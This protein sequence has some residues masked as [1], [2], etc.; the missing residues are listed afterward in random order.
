MKTRLLKYLF[1]VFFCCMA[2]SFKAFSQTISFTAL[3]GTASTY[4]SAGGNLY[5]VFGFEMKTTGFVSGSNCYIQMGTITIN[6]TQ[7]NINTYFSNAMLVQTTNPSGITSTSPSIGTVNV[8]SSNVTI[9]LNTTFSSN[10]DNTYYLVYKTANFTGSSTISFSFPTSPVDNN[11]FF[12]ENNVKNYPTESTATTGNANQ[13]FILGPAPVTYDWIGSTTSNDWNVTTNWSP[14]GVPGANDVARIGVSHGYS[15]EPTVKTN[16]SVG[17]ITFG[18]TISGSGSIQPVLTVNNGCTLSVT[19]DITYQSDAQSGSGYVP[20]VS[21]TG[22]G[23]IKAVNLNAVSG[24]T[25]SYHSFTEI[26]NSS[27][28][29]LILSGNIALTSDYVVY[30]GRNYYFNSTFD[31]TGGNTTVNGVLKSTNNTSGCTSTFE[32]LPT[33][34]AAGATFLRLANSVALSGL[35]STTGT[36]NT[37]SFN[38]YGATV[39]YSGASQTV[40]TDATINSITTRPVYFSIKFSGTGI[41]IPNNGKLQVYGN[42]IDSLSNDATD[43]LSLVS[44]PVYFEGNNAQTI[45]CGTGNGAT[46]S[47]A[48]FNNSTTKTLSSGYFNVA[49]TGTLIMQDTSKSP[50]LTV[51]GGLLTLMSSSS[52]TAQV[53]TLTNGSIQGSNINVQRYIQAKRDYRLLS[54]P[55]NQTNYTPSSSSSSPN[56]IDISY[57]GLHPSP[58]PGTYYGA[59][60]AGPGSGFTHSNPNAVIYLY[61]ESLIPGTSINSGFTTSNNVGVIGYLSSGNSSVAYTKSTAANGATSYSNSTSGVKLPVG[62]GYLLYYIGRNDGTISNPKSNSVNTTNITSAGYLNQGTIPAYIWCNPGSLTYTFGSNVP[63]LTMLGNPYAATLDLQKFYNDNATFLLGNYTSL[64]LNGT[65]FVLDG[66]DNSNFPTFN[67]ASN[68]TS[69]TSSPEFIASGQGF[70]AETTL[71]APLAYALGAS[72]SFKEDQKAITYS[73]AG[74]TYLAATRSSKTISSN[75]HLK[76]IEDTTNVDECGLYFNKNWSDTFDNF[77]SKDHD[78]LAPV[79]Y[80][81]SY[82]SDNIRTCI[83]A[84]R[85]YNYGKRIRL[86]V[87][88]NTDGIYKLNLEDITNID[89]INYKVYLIDTKLNDSLDMVHYRTYSFNLHTADTA[90]FANRFVLAIERKLTGP[91]SLIAFSGQK[92]TGGIQLNW[93]TVN[94]GNYTGFGLEKL[95]AKGQYSLIDSVQSTGAGVYNFND[96]NPVMGNNIYRLAQNDIHGKVTFAGPIN[97]NYNTISVSGMFTIY[98]NPSKDMINIAVNSGT[99]GSQN[100]PV[101]LASIYDLSGT[102]I[103]SRQVNTNNWTQDITGYKAGVYILELKSAAGNIIGKAKFVKT[104]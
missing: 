38:N 65:F 30:G 93:N 103:N 42:F 70:Y 32:I 62:N 95:G 4:L 15:S 7:A 12:F 48:Y 53:A 88:A 54:S 60:I 64:V 9:N 63:G 2:V 51:N 17:S 77:D 6:T 11:T 37:L 89:T 31:L 85:D 90:D 96:K 76:L 20:Y 80:L 49:S 55:T 23:T 78:G 58:S 25:A 33:A 71:G 100:T 69:G 16:K 13:T 66:T 22:N 67:A 18:N 87:K 84:M 28:D 29:S 72:L 1:A 102:M 92:A 21:L 45:K 61:Q 91:Y 73:N 83:N 8:S 41:K 59:Y 94:E 81:S 98:P 79:V 36:T 5:V 19:N 35:S 40:Y 68:G 47:K 39:E 3:P 10:V 97:I 27:I 56:I 99:T 24:N 44:T 74:A 50:I 52:G 104:N 46:F 14:A 101:Y 75:M 34:S 86:Y 57:L 82:S 26:I 43:S